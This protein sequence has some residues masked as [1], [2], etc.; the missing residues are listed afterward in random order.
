MYLN[1][2]K[3]GS[4]IDKNV[5]TTKIPLKS[6]RLVFKIYNYLT[7]KNSSNFCYYRKGFKVVHPLFIHILRI[8]INLIHKSVSC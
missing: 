1:D 8:C 3:T 6:N 7:Q 4:K 5:F 2:I